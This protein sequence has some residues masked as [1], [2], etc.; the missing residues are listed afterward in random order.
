MKHTGFKVVSSRPGYIVKR[1]LN[2]I[3]TAVA[4]GDQVKQ[5]TD[6]TAER[7]ASATIDLLGIVVGINDSTGK[8]VQVAPAST[9]GYTV[10]VDSDP[11]AILSVQADA[12]DT[13]VLLG[14]ACDGTFTAPN[15]LGVSTEKLGISTKAGD[16][17]S[18]QYIV[19][20][21]IDMLDNDYTDSNAMYLVR[22]NEH[23][24]KY[25]NVAI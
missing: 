18:A 12:A 21:K 20:G 9:S 10:L 8:A 6:G 16:G 3:A 4:I 19:I 22:P 13:V 7:M 11:D 2:A 25:A 15:S 1:S 17:S 24:L 5:N 14:E 23:S